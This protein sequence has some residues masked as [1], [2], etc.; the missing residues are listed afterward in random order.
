MDKVQILSMSGEGGQQCDTGGEHGGDLWVVG[1]Q[2]REEWSLLNT[3]WTLSVPGQKMRNGIEWVTFCPQSK[4]WIWHK[5]LLVPTISSNL[6]V[7]V[8]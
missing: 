3:D 4:G 8:D 5:G 2:L 6:L 7:E 1:Q